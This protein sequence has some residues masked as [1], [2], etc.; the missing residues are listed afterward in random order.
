[1][2]LKIKQLFGNERGNKGFSL[3]ELL[4]AV[5][6][7]AILVAVVYGMLVSY[8]EAVLSQESSVEIQQGA[9][10]AVG[11][12][13]NDLEMIGANVSDGEG[14][15]SMI[16]AASWELVF[17]G[18]LGKVV[19]KT[20]GTLEAVGELDPDEPSAKVDY[21]YGMVVG[22]YTGGDPGDG[23]PFDS[24]AETVRYYIRTPNG[25][26][27][28]DYSYHLNDR[29]LV[30]E[31]NGSENMSTV[32]GFGIRAGL[33]PDNSNS[34][35][36]EDNAQVQPLFKYWGDWDFDNTTPDSLWGDSDFDGV[37]STDEITALVGGTYQ[38]SYTSPT[39]TTVLA[40][41]YADGGISLTGNGG[42]ISNSEDN[43]GSISGA[44]E[45]AEDVNGN[46]RL[47]QNLLD[48]QLHRIEIDLGVIAQTPGKRGQVFAHGSKY[49]EARVTSNVF[50]RNI[51]RLPEK[52]GGNPPAP[53]TSCGA[54]VQEC[55]E[56]VLVTFTAS[57]DDGKGEQDV[58]MYEVFRKITED[59]DDDTAD[60][61]EGSENFNFYTII[62][63]Q[64]LDTDGTLRDYEISD[65]DVDDGYCYQYKIIAVDAAD[66]KSTPCMT[67][68]TDDSCASGA[69]SPVPVPGDGL[70]GR[71]PITLWDTPCHVSADELG[72]I[73]LM[74][75]QSMD[76][77]FVDSTIDEYWIYRSQ[78][79]DTEET[80]EEYNQ[81]VVGKVPVSEID[82]SCLGVSSHPECIDYTDII[83]AECKCRDEDLYEWASLPYKYMIWRDQEDSPGK[84][85]SPPLNGAAFGI[86]TSS[87]FDEESMN[88]Y[89]YAVRA[90]RSTDDCLSDPVVYVSECTP[91]YNEA[92][93]FNS[94][95]DSLVHSRYSPPME[96]QVNDVS[97]YISGG[98]YESA[99]KVK[100]SWTAS[101]SEF[102]EFTSAYADSDIPDLT[103]YY[104]YR[105]KW[106]QQDVGTHIAPVM[107]KEDNSS[108]PKI[109]PEINDDNPARILVYHGR[110]RGGK[111]SGANVWHG[112]DGYDESGSGGSGYPYF[113][114]WVDSDQRITDGDVWHIAT[115]GTLDLSP[116]TFG[117]AVQH[118]DADFVMPGSGTMLDPV[119]EYMVAAVSANDTLQYEGALPTE[120]PTPVTGNEW[121]FGAACVKELSFDCPCFFGVQDVSIDYCGLVTASDTDTDDAVVISWRWAGNLQPTYVDDNGVTQPISSGL[122][123]V[124]NVQAPLTSAD[125][126]WQLAD[127]ITYND[128]GYGS[129][130]DCIG[131]H[132]YEDFLDANGNPG[133]GLV[134]QY[135]VRMLCYSGDDACLRIQP[136]NA[137]EQAGFPDEAHICYK[138]QHPAGSTD[139]YDSGDYPSAYINA[140]G[141]ATGANC[142]TGEVRIEL[143]EMMDNCSTQILTEDDWVWWRVVRFSAINGQAWPT[144]PENGDY[145]CV[146]SDPLCV[147]PNAH[148]DNETW[149]CVSTVYSNGA[150]YAANHECFGTT[151]YT[152]YWLRVGEA[153]FT[154]PGQT[155]TYH[156]SSD[157][158]NY[159]YSNPPT[160]EYIGNESGMKRYMFSEIVNPNLNYKYVFTIGI[161]HPPEN[162]DSKPLC[163][164][165]P[166]PIGGDQCNGGF[167]GNTF[168]DAPYKYSVV[169]DFS[170]TYQCYPPTQY[171]SYGGRPAGDGLPSYP[172]SA[173]ATDNFSWSAGAIERNTK[174]WKSWEWSWTL[175]HWTITFFGVHYVLDWTIGDH[176]FQYS[177]S[178][179]RSDLDGLFGGLLAWTFSY[180]YT[181][182]FGLC[183]WHFDIAGVTVFA[184]DW[185]WTTCQQDLTNL[186]NHSYL[187]SNFYPPVCHSNTIGDNHKI[188]YDYMAQMHLQVTPT[189]RNNS[190]AIHGS[191]TPWDLSFQVLTLE[192]GF[193]G[194][195]TMGTRLIHMAADNWETVGNYSENIGDNNLD[196]DWYSLFF[197]T[198]MNRVTPAYLGETFMYIWVRRDPG[199]S[200]DWKNDLSFNMYNTAPTYAWTSDGRT[201]HRT[202]RTALPEVESRSGC[203]CSMTG[204]NSWICTSGRPL[205]CVLPPAGA[206]GF[207]AEP[208]VDIRNTEYRYD[209]LRIDPYCGKC[210]PDAL[211]TSTQAAFTDA[212]Q[213][214][215]TYP[216]ENNSSPVY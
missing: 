138:S 84:V 4:V 89:T 19:T 76:G 196:D 162:I 17:N 134:F 105:S 36:Y 18:D 129:K 182:G 195:R 110:V 147:I 184:V 170:N 46:G 53:P 115:G 70:I 57:Y 178:Y 191:Y 173:G 169:V 107:L 205:R 148:N 111:V 118:F 160:L 202:V 114:S 73:T 75:P 78:P 155:M 102:C 172:A 15:H 126:N 199:K 174:P 62:P 188:T 91:P 210:P 159:P 171:G 38:Y 95:K 123:L 128:C 214:D 90:H 194:N 157:A 136:L 131:Y 72:S 81:L 116:N 143:R 100:V 6:L 65:T 71:D 192:L 43:L 2:G 77:G 183:T 9:R 41:S 121:S 119:Y 56:S 33:N 10:Y 198:C 40:G 35:A 86:T 98:S 11:K 141:S 179:M 209:N 166:L 30:R 58:V 49:P 139:C 161:K 132:R 92:Q 25:D 177:G 103:R 207:Y 32:V 204:S 130:P 163:Y 140:G 24:D 1:M 93:S 28:K 51:G 88:R 68:D 74:W 47:D 197:L 34:M 5:T 82:N 22:T 97:D 137:N 127:I 60:D 26:N 158:G 154:T 79:N 29:E 213:T 85:G 113:Y 150:Q 42:A 181:I 52:S 201:N 14:Q 145:E 23:T 101:P 87:N 135:G 48:S 7:T 133:Y 3:I 99:A 153:N 94:S 83:H 16:Y 80:F 124:Y 55:G 63:A 59:T 108:P 146:P 117:G 212:T 215:G 216:V 106:P 206:F 12:I 64:G 152:G 190:I 185:F 37:L 211:W 176:G 142:Q 54:E 61:D 208:F 8:R 151:H 39:G 122:E 44:L 165:Q 186:R 167:D 45:A 66:Q 50:L 175:F 168:S 20:D 164:A 149:P 193:S 67:P 200:H 203:G 156:T 31:I 112:Y 180:I 96:F 187:W 109:T 125:S 104:I 189:D 144:E 120:D 69:L 21:G 13:K 27:S